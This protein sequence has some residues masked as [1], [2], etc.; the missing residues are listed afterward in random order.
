MTAHRPAALPSCPKVQPGDDGAPHPS[1]LMS[2]LQLIDANLRAAL[3]GSFLTACLLVWLVWLASPAP[4]PETWRDTLG[5]IIDWP[6]ASTESRASSVEQP[7][8]LRIRAAVWLIAYALGAATC[9]TVWQ[10]I[11][12]KNQRI[13]SSKQR[14]GV[15]QML[16]LMIGLLWGVGCSWLFQPAS[17]TVTLG[18]L[19]LVAGLSSG[20]L[21]GIGVLAR[22]YWLVC[23][24]M[25]AGLIGALLYQGSPV[26]P[27]LPIALLVLMGSNGIFAR[28]IEQKI[29][30]SIELRLENIALV[31]QLRQR[32]DAAEQANLAKSRFLAN[33][34][35]DLRQPVHALNLFLESLS[36][37][38]LDARQETIIR[39]AKAASRASREL[40]DTL[41]DFSR[42]EAGIMQPR[43]TWVPLAG[44][45]R[46][47]EDEFGPQADSKGLVYRCRDCFD[48]VHSDA[49]LLLVIL[50]NLVANAI[51][52]T[53]RGGVLVAVRSRGADRVIE[54]WDT[55]VGIDT[56]HH[57]AIFQEFHQIAN[58]ERDHRK[59]L[60]LG[61]AIVRRLVQAMGLEL[62]LASRPGRGSVFCLRLPGISGCAPLADEAAPAASSF[63]GMRT[64]AAPLQGLKV[65]LV[66]DEILVLEGM[67]TLLEKWG[68]IVAAFRDREGAVQH[69]QRFDEKDAQPFDLL[70]TDYRLENG[71]T[72]GQVIQAVYAALQ[73]R[74]PGCALA[75][76]SIILTGDTD[77]SRIV[78]AQGVGA[79]LLHKPIETQVLH[80][81]IT[82]LFSVP[83]NPPPC[84]QARSQKR[85][86]PGRHASGPQLMA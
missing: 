45:L 64:C 26:N 36:L 22:M 30:R 31:E 54:V 85:A 32:T 10:R 79:M 81:Q 14:Y 48:S 6:G 44:L 66:D 42:I 16:A 20:V 67:R 58:Q 77:P 83:E 78:Q 60:G 75:P 80:D 2:Q 61:L 1:L 68:C 40:L 62:T 24:P 47:L 19:C 5:Q 57:E 63:A 56:R 82:T 69:V 4:P 17:D 70:I 25:I 76:P 71:V 7:A 13:Y 35:H 43:P 11:W 38:V 51:R 59:G 53:E 23:L 18:M 72:G 86:R 34:S 55:G 49:A 21:S 3:I 65:L 84:M 15:I 46:Q 74:C 39:H 12:Q 9:W 37:T 33:A 27:V 73:L 8:L 50:R 41:L 29:S 28:N 52:Y